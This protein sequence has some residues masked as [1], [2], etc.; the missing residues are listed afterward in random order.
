MPYQSLRSHLRKIGMMK[1]P[2]RVV[3][4][5]EGHKAKQKYV[6]PHTQESKDFSIYFSGRQHSNQEISL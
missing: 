6:L 4:P 1:L 5:V 3:Q 2:L